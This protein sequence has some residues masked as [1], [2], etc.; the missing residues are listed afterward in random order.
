MQTYT[1]SVSGCAGLMTLEEL[2]SKL[3]EVNDA[4]RL[5]QAELEALTR[6][7]EHIEQLEKDRES[8]LKSMAEIVPD[9][10]EGLTAV[11][12]DFDPH[13]RCTHERLRRCS[14]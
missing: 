3:Q 10:L 14:E 1:M 12:N 9:A 6:R 8:L 13:K 11:C 5:A 4:R 2:G 7:Q